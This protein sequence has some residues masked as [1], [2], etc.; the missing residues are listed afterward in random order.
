MVAAIIDRYSLGQIDASEAPS[1]ARLALAIA[2]AIELQDVNPGCLVSI[3]P[4]DDPLWVPPNGAVV[5]DPRSDS[6]MISSLVL[7]GF[8]AAGRF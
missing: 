2:V 3:R 1:Q 8:L 6:R 5:L 7:V 4:M